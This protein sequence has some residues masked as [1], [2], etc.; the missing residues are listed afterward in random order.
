MKKYNLRIL[1]GTSNGYTTSV[2]CDRLDVIGRIYYFEIKKNDKYTVKSYYPVDRT[3][4]ESIE[5]L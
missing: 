2:I 4:I 1:S 3:I 5:D